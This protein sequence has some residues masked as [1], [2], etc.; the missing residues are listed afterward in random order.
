M[1]LPNLFLLAADDPSRLLQVLR[2][3]PSLAS[4]QDEQGYSLL[5]AA[6]SYNHVELLRSL[7]QEFHVQV[8]L[9]DIDGETALY[10]A[11]TIDCARLL[12]EELN[13]DMT[14]R[15]SEGKTALQKITEEDEFPHVA[16]YLRTK[17]LENLAAGDQKSGA[18]NHVSASS[19]IPSLPDGFS[20]KFSTVAPEEI[21]DVLDSDM[22]QKIEQ[23]ASRP[24]FDTDVGQNAL[25]ELVKD[26]LKSKETE[27]NT[28]Q[29]TI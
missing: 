14:I 4:S 5:H 8:D 29:K 24:D 11:E 23:L 27:R 21:G 22:K 15:S 25:R 3:S 17:E 13:A 9:R 18:Q 28:R 7:V 20:V 12:V 10:V 19:E 26:V 16:V 1:A 2:E 6:A